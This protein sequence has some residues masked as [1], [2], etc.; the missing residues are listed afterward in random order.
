MARREP[1]VAKTVYIHRNGIPSQSPKRMVVNE[2]Q[3]RDFNTFLTR[4]TSGLRA[5]VAVRNIYTPA[6]GRRI[7]KLDDL[8]SGK[9]YVAGGVEHFKKIKYAMHASPL[10]LYIYIYIYILLQVST[11]SFAVSK[12]K[13]T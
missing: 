9:H 10:A 13:G 6:G 1:K 3:V 2:R 11:R 7:Q 12:K 4:V 8:E 5:P